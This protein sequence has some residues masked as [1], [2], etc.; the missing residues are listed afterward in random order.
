V[1]STRA[2]VDRVFPVDEVTDAFDHLASPGKFGKV[3]VEF[4][5]R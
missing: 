5:A 2:I 4:A 3:L 1:P